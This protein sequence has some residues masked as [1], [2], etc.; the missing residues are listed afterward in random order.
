MKNFGGAL[1]PFDYFVAEYI[2]ELK[3]ES[4]ENT[5][6][7]ERYEKDIEN[8]NEMNL[9]IVDLILKHDITDISIMCM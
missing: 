8:V 6:K 7:V 9:K 3:G 5:Y 4:E 2:E 1:T